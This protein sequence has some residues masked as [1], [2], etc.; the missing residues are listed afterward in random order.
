M[1]TMT[2]TG[3]KFNLKLRGMRQRSGVGESP[4]RL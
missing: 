3:T 1:I 2:A 4:F